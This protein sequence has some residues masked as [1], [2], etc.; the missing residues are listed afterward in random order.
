V[1]LATA[2]GSAA[3]GAWSPDLPSSSYPGAGYGRFAFPD[4]SNPAN[5]TMKWNVVFR[6]GVTSPGSYYYR[7][8]LAVGTLEDVRV[9]LCQIHSSVQ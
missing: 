3:M 1:V 2:D 8:Y 6:R 7:S 5:A 4:A 9:A